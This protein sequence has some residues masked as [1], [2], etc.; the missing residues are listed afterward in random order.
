MNEIELRPDLT[1]MP[2]RIKA[3]PVYRGYPVPWFVAYPNGPEGEPEFRTADSRK[4]IS[5]VQDRRCWVCGDALGSFLTFVLGPM[6]GI[7][8]TT[9]EPATHREC[10]EWSVV[11]CPFLVRPHMV[12]REGNLPEGV[13]DPPGVCL[14]RN[15][16]V[17][18][19]WITRRFTLFR[20][21]DRRY[22]I[23]VGDPL[24]VVCYAEGRKASRAEVDSSIAG[25]L[26]K[27]IEIAK[28]EGREAEL[29]LVRQVEAFEFYLPAR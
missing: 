27:L 2:E 19:L 14:L 28:Q 11:N 18:L 20:A 21:Q 3:L 25:G 6:C 13:V 1:T 7:T 22:L 23:R 16:G 4:W 15:P 12:R 26:P 17:T 9:S 29:E 10:A 8:R 24:E 5:A